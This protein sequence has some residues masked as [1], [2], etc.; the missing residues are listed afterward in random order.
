VAVE[1]GRCGYGMEQELVIGSGGRVWWEELELGGNWRGGRD[2]GCGGGG[3]AVWSCA[4]VVFE[5]GVRNCR[6]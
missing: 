1:A 6:S 4:V 3:R 5:V 2:V